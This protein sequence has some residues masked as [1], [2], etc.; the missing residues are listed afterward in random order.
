M[1]RVRCAVA[2]RCAGA[3][4]LGARAVRVAVIGAALR[5][6]PHA[7]PPVLAAALAANDAR[8][9]A[10]A[11]AGAR[12]IGAAL[13]APAAIAGAFSADARPVSVAVL[14]ARVLFA[15]VAAPAGS[16]NT[17]AVDALAVPE[18]RMAT[19]RRTGWHV[20]RARVDGAL[21][22]LPADVTS[23]Q[24]ATAGGM[25][26]ARRQK[27]AAVDGAELV[28]PAH[29]AYACARRKQLSVARAGRELG[30]GERDA[31]HSGLGRRRRHA[32]P[33]RTSTTTTRDQGQGD[34]SCPCRPS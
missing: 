5:L 34:S 4:A 28:E 12:D 22:R 25:A 10:I 21:R 23:A 8:A 6:T 7:H 30:L 27:S 1:S 17:P 20:P 2:V 18:G 9:V 24:A 11:A 15:R 26:R 32:D 19:E 3:H 31:L 13:A 33:E 14:R 29:V 16:T